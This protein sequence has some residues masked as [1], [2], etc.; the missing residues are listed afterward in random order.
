LDF[1]ATFIIPI[2][3]MPRRHSHV[4]VLT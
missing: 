2:K 3:I 4:I 1:F